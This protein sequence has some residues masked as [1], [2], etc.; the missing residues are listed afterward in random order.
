MEQELFYNNFNTFTNNLS[1]EGGGLFDMF[2]FDIFGNLSFYYLLGS[3]TL[4]FFYLNC[5]KNSLFKNRVEE[6]FVNLWLV[7]IIS[8]PL[9]V[10]FA[11]G[12]VPP[13]YNMIIYG[14]LALLMILG[15]LFI[16]F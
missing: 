1:L 11:N 8:S 2:G 6:V 12:K 10:N 15:I 5:Q 7:V 3:V 13:P 4:L 16:I 14:I 9:L